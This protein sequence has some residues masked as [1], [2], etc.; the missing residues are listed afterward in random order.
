MLRNTARGCNAQQIE[1]FLK[2]DFPRD[3]MSADNC[4]HRAASAI[5]GAL[6]ADAACRPLHWIY[7][8]DA[9]QRHVKELSPDGNPEF[10]SE[11]R[12]PFYSIPTGHLSPY[13]AALL[14]S[15]EGA[16]LSTA[17]DASTIASCI[18]KSLSDTFGADDSDWQISFRLRNMEYDEK[19]K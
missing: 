6:C 15:L 9:I 3:S 5:V 1:M 19:N 10:L 7:D 4:H 18:E 16:A 8:T 17:S 2:K 11:S 13:G 12:S 14:A